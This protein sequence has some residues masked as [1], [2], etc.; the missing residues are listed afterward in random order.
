MGSFSPLFSYLRSA[1]PS[2]AHL[3]FVRISRCEHL[4]FYMTYDD[5]VSIK[6][7]CVHVYVHLHINKGYPFYAIK[8]NFIINYRYNICACKLLV[9]V[10]RL[11][12]QQWD[13]FSQATPKSKRM[14]IDVNSSWV[15][16]KNP[17]VPGW[18]Q[19]GRPL[20]P[21][22]SGRLADSHFSADVNVQL[23]LLAVS[24]QFDCS[25][26]ML[27]GYVRIFEKSM[28]PLASLQ[29]AM[30]SRFLWAGKQAAACWVK[31][32]VA[33]VRRDQFHPAGWVHHAAQNHQPFM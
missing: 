32:Y 27:R 7:L 22:D 5:Y 20:R 8:C 29:P 21:G 24:I 28:L 19:K 9:T 3:R 18:L 12:T 1:L 30:L 17:I 31:P 6:S 14:S 10:P 13:P 11:W 2:R 16:S 23:L 4:L 15:K 25:I 26:P 33:W